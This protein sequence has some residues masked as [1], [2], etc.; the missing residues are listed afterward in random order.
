MGDLVKEFEKYVDDSSWEDIAKMARTY[1]LEF[2][3]EDAEVKRLKKQVRMTKE[4]LYTYLKGED[5]KV[6]K[7]ATFFRGLVK[8]IEHFEKSLGKHS[9]KKAEFVIFLRALLNKIKKEKLVVFKT[10]ERR[11]GFEKLKEVGDD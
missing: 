10:M 4:L 3:K 1:S 6:I 9:A 7:K 5:K 8:S 11:K 2:A